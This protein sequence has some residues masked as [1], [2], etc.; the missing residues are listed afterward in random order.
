MGNTGYKSFASLEKYY[1]DDNSYA[2]ETKPNVVTDPNYIAPV[3]DTETCVPSV[4]YYNTVQTL[5]AT[6]NNCSSGY[7]GSAVTLTAHA[8]QFVS[9]T[10]V[11]DANDQAEVWLTANAQVYANISGTCTL[12]YYNTVQTMKAT[13]DNCPS[14][15]TGSE[16]TLTAN[17][18]Q[19]ESII[20]VEDAN[21]K[22]IVWLTANAQTYANSS[23]T[24]VDSSAPTTTSLGYSLITS[25]TLTLS[26]TV[27]TDNVGV[28]GYDIYRNGVLLDSTAS[29]VLSYAVTGLS[30][31]TP[32]SFYVKVKD[33]AGNSSTS[34][35]VNITTP[36]SKLILVASKSVIFENQDPSW[37]NCKSSP[38]ADYIHT[39]NKVIGSGLSS[40]VFYLNRYRGIID[41]S[42]IVNRPISAKI[43]FKFDTNTLGSVLTMNLFASNTHIPLS[44][45]LQVSDW[46]DWDINSF[47]NSVDVLSN[48]VSYNEIP[49]TSTQLDLLYSEQAYN[50]FIISNGDKNSS[51]PSTNNRPELSILQ[52]TGEVYLECEF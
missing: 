38:S 9:A 37:Y 25:T 46:N 17:A 35:A 21:N 42:L 44:E 7:A 5:Q 16:V 31:A 43:K 28:V 40:S 27:S 29:N 51:E 14:G 13:K 39:T 48:S 8:N 11:E 45:T 3:L 26:W 2:G 15:Y 4:R 47:I 32:Y 6:K 20:S 23:G 50:F 22:A 19:F 12:I 34:N 10:S 52:S 24:C 49:L 41:T 18:N 33:A 36:P 30:E 1:T